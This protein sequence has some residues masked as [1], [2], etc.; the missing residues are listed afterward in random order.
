MFSGRIDAVCLSEKRGIAK[1]NLG[2]GYLKKDFGLQG[3]AH[4][5]PGEKQISILLNQFVEPLT[6]KLGERP[7][8]GSFAENLL[9]SGLPE[10]SIDRGTLLRAGEAVIEITAVGKDSSER[11]TYS[12]KGY[13]LLADQGL[14][15]RVVKGGR[16][17]V[18]DTVKI[19]DSV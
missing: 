14:F 9:V 5:G 3:D 7:L 18:G 12:Y 6:E 15:G 19:L 2:K 11:H 10:E 4:A 13:S 1:T 16:V 8:P 17:R